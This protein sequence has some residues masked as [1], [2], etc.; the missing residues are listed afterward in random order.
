MTCRT[1]YLIRYIELLIRYRIVNSISLYRIVNSI[2]RNSISIYKIKYRRI[3]YIYRN[4]SIYR[5]N[6]FTYRAS[7]STD[8]ILRYRRL[9]IRYIGVINRYTRSKNVTCPFQDSK[10]LKLASL[11][12]Y[13]LITEKDTKIQINNQS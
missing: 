8:R 13:L 1:L 2:Y 6:N 9:V 4:K 5:I 7:N 3:I 10:S 11:V 12:M